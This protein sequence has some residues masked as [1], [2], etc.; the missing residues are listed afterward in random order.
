[1]KSF[2][3]TPNKLKT[4]TTDEHRIEVEAGR[5]AQPPAPGVL[6]CACM[7]TLALEWNPVSSRPL[8]DFQIV[9]IV[10]HDLV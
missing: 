9:G 10:S 6:E 5:S 1:M 4:V 2:K 7:S 8:R 3:H